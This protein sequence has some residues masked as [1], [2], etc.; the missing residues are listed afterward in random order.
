[1]INWQVST[2]SCKLSDVVKN[3]AVKKTVYDKLVIKVNNV[4]TSDFPLK[5]KYNTDK[6]ELEIKFLMWLILLKK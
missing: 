2:S 1:M 6:T 5:T 3:G 4:D